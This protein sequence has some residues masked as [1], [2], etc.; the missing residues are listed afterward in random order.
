M[1]KQLLI[2]LLDIP[3]SPNWIYRE[4]EVLAPNF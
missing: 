3:L 2:S 1:D 4:L